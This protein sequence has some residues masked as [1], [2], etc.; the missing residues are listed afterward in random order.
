MSTKRSSEKASRQNGL[1]TLCAT[2]LAS[3]PSGTL[4][5]R[6]ATLA[7]NVGNSKHRGFGERFG[8]RTSLFPRPLICIKLFDCNPATSLLVP[9]AL[10]A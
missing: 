2:A 9:R 8:R 4:Q 10:L 6:V 5:G 7:L 1:R 3:Y